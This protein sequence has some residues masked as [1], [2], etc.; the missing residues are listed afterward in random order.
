MNYLKISFFQ[1]I[2][3]LF[4]VVL[5]TSC[6]VDQ[7]E[8][9]T[10]PDEMKDQKEMP[11]PE[12][13]LDTEVDIILPSNIDLNNKAS[14]DEFMA[15]I[16]EE[17]LAELVEHTRLADYI[18]TINKEKQVTEILGLGEL[19]TVEK[20]TPIL[21]DK[22]LSNLNNFTQ[23]EVADDRACSGW[24]A[25]KTRWNEQRMPRTNLC[26][27]HAKIWYQTRTCPWNYFFSSRMRLIKQGHYVPCWQWY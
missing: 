9:L 23:I 27:M 19:L 18:T 20:I 13:I 16:T 3:T 1:S 21:N 5:I 11:Q 12:F 17:R 22:E 6:G 8:L 7:N 25:T 15:S 10:T 4:V 14:V 2:L 26:M 24:S